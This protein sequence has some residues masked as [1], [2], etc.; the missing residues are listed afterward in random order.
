MSFKLKSAALVAAGIS[1]GI[2]V[3]N[4]K[5]ADYIHGSVVLKEKGQTMPVMIGLGEGRKTVA[6]SVKNLQAAEDV[7]LTIDG[8]TIRSTFPPPIVLPFR[9][10]IG[11]K[12]NTFQGLRYGQR[13]PLFI[14]LGGGRCSYELV[15]SR[16]SDGKLIKTIPL[17]SGEDHGKSH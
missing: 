15:F 9:K 10:W 12:D 17:I 4:F 16:G 5:P 13:V 3:A 8:G 2:L 1:I 7:R 11:F 14:T 6:L